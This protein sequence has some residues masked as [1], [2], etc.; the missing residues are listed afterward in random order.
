M[1]RIVRVISKDASV[2]CSAIDGKDIVGEIERIHKTS[3]VVTAALGRLSLGA[4]LMGFGLKGKDDTVTVR[5]NGDGPAGALIAV[6]DSFGNVKSYVQNPVV[7]LPLNSYGKLDVRGAVGRNGTLSVVKDLGLKEPY[8]GQVPIVSGEIAEDITSYLAVSE[9]IPSVCALGVLVNPDLTVANAGG[10]L[11][12]LLPFA[13]ESAIDVIENNIKNLKSVTQLYSQGMT[14]DEIALKTLEGLEPN[15]L[16]D[17][18]VNYKCDCSRDRVSRALQSIGEADL[19]EMANDE[20]T[21]VQCH[22]C[23]KV[24]RF[25]SAEVEALIKK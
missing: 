23:D 18:E 17:F 9:Q 22:F 21:E 10:Y 8:S 13:P 25:T 4:S 19:R 3:A 1:G 20:I 5:L 7:E 15:I 14:V 11:I 2:V 6:A 24:Y 16:D 12:Q